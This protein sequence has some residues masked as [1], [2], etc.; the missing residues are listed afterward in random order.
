MSKKLA[1][2][3][4]VVALVVLLAACS[5]S[6]STTST[7]AAASATTAAPE[8]TTTAAASAQSLTITPNTGLHD[9]Q[10][11][12]VVGTGYTPG[13]TNLGI[14][15]CADK[16]AQTGAG[17]CNL[18]AIK[19]GAGVVPNATGKVSTTYVVHKGPFG[20]NNIV[21]SATQKCLVSLGELTATPTEEA[22]M[23]ISFA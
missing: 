21:C 17:D 18:G 10:T 5:S 2:I 12:Q 14:N 22:T 23:N 11:V 19:A 8:T 7:T 6:K 4:I 16:G 9:G 20:Q 3:G 1:S 13:K 15:E